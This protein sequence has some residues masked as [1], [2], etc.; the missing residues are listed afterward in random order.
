MWM[1]NIGGIS[2]CGQWCARM[3]KKG[4]YVSFFCIFMMTPSYISWRG[5]KGAIPRLKMTR[6]VVSNNIFWWFLTMLWVKV[7]LQAPILWHQLPFLWCPSLPMRNKRITWRNVF[8]WASILMCLYV[9]H[10]FNF[11][12]I[13]IIQSTGACL[14]H[15]DF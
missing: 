1:L 6:L 15:Y 12:C 13:I 4:T 10:V 11:Q 14:H 9:R 7:C 3:Y 2:L 8:L 5:T